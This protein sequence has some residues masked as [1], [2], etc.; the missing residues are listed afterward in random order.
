MTVYCRAFH[1]RSVKRGA[2]HGGDVG[3]FLSMFSKIMDLSQYRSVD[4]IE[5][6]VRTFIDECRLYWDVIP[7]NIDTNRYYLIVLNANEGFV[8]SDVIYSEY[9][10]IP[11]YVYSDLPITAHQVWRVINCVRVIEEEY[12]DEVFH[13]EEVEVKI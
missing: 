10:L 4:E 11:I 9:N 6:A 1:I 5:K 3:R 13:G 7:F 8:V 2:L 12:P